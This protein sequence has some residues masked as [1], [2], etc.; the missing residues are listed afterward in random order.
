M[1][2]RV[3]GAML[4]AALGGVLLLI[5]LFLDWYEPGLTAWDVFEIADLVLA[6]TGIAAIIAIVRPLVGHPG[7]SEEIRAGILFYAGVGALIITVAGMI[8]PPPAAIESDPEVGAWL[9]LAGA[10]LVT[11]GALLAKSHVS[12]VITSSPR[13]PRAEPTEPH[14]PTGPATDPEGDETDTRPLGPA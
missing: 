6:A 1:S 4:I 2:D 13:R 3:N 14:A 7:A 8:Q 9:G 5:S 12:I 10:V 11:A